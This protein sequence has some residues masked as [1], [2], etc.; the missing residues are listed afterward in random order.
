MICDRKR[1][2]NVTCHFF[3]LISTLCGSYFGFLYILV[4][5][6]PFEDGATTSVQILSLIRISDSCQKNMSFRSSI[7]SHGDKN[8][9]SGWRAERN[10]N[11]EKLAI[12]GISQTL[13]NQCWTNL[14][15]CICQNLHRGRDFQHFILFLFVHKRIM[16]VFVCAQINMY[17]RIM[18]V[19]FPFDCI[20][21]TNCLSCH[22][23][24]VLLFCKPLS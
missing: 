3:L 9:G 16:F 5:W 8:V 1:L 10:E 4:F 11:Q 19:P 24:P 20:S 17:I 15:N 6:W 23:Q 21:L 13:V 12:T 7:T 14:W 2:Q 22:L 18:F